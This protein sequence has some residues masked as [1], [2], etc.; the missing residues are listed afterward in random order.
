MVGVLEWVLSEVLPREFL[1]LR[2][3]LFGIESLWGLCSRHETQ[4]FRCKTSGLGF[5]VNPQNF[6]IVPKYPGSAWTATQL[7]AKPR[8]QAE[9]SL[10]H[11]PKCEA[12]F[13]DVV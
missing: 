7:Y 5:R 4:E 3:L 13:Q 11:A 12:R 2:I 10:A 8:K 6:E 9:N 1:N